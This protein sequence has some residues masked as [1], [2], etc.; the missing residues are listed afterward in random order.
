M[1]HLE[2]ARVNDLI[3]LKIGAIQ[4]EAQ[5]LDVNSA[6]QEL[7]VNLSALEKRT[8]DLKVILEAIPHDHP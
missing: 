1:T 3:G 8:A 4:E 6:L 7:E 2:T 5:K